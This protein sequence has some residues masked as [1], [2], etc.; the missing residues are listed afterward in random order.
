MYSISG[1]EGTVATLLHCSVYPHLETKTI[2]YV[3]DIHKYEAYMYTY[4]DC[5]SFLP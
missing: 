5:T 1:I 4:D 2:D 3:H